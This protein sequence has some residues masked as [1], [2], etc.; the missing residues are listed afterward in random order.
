[1]RGSTFR[2]QIP[3][4]GAETTRSIV[5]PGSFTQPVVRSG[6]EVQ[7][8]AVSPRWIPFPAAESVL[9]PASPSPRRDVF[10]TDD[11]IRNTNEGFAVMSFHGTRLHDRGTHAG[12]IQSP[13][14]YRLFAKVSAVQIELRRCPCLAPVLGSHCQRSQRDPAA[15]SAGVGQREMPRGVA[16]QPTPRSGAVTLKCKMRRRSWASTR[17]T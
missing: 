11:S 2:T 16:V 9:A 10:S 3:N 14:L 4:G 7:Q 17:K 12:S 1:V 13:A 6:D 15:G 8:P 5:G